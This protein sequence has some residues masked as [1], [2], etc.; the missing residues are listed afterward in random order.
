MAA[1]TFKAI[2]ALL[3]PRKIQTVTQAV[4]KV[5]EKNKSA[6]MR[7]IEVAGVGA[8]AFSVKYDE[9]GFPG[10]TLFAPHAEMHRGCDSIAFCELEGK[11]YILCFELKSSE[12]TRHEVAKQFRSASVFLEYLDTLLKT[13]CKSASIE[14][15]PRYYFVFHNQA[16]TPLGK[17]TSRDDSDN[18]TPGQARFI[19]KTTGAKIYLRELLG[20]PL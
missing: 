14:S 6:T 8:S 3:N 18:I 19:A 10:Q 7:L 5:E 1:D 20:K 2:Q 9:C 11:P 4:L 16:A 12:P 17:R 15:W 13:Y